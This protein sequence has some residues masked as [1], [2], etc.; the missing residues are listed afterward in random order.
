MK[1]DKEESMLLENLLAMGAIVVALAMFLVLIYYTLIA[2]QGKPID[3]DQQ[4]W[5]HHPVL[6][7]D[8]AYLAASLYPA[9][10]YIDFPVLPLTRDRQNVTQPA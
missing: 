2:Q 3:G 1:L 9:P 4:V 5:H 8:M 10:D 7:D 6:D